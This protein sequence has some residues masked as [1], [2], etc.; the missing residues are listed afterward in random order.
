VLGHDHATAE[1]TRAMRSREL[2]LLV[3]HH[4]HGPA[5]DGFRHDHA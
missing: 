4:W 1:E 2:D 5:P 3:R